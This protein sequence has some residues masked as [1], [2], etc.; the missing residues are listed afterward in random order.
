MRYASVFLNGNF[1][2]V[3]GRID[4][5]WSTKIARLDTANWS[6]SQA[7]ELNQARYEHRAIWV[8]SKLVVVGGKWGTKPI[9]FCKLENDE[10]LGKKFTCT[11]QNST[12]PQDSKYPLLFA[13]SDD[14]KNC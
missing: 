1:Y 6:W 5:K 3:G 8:N 14:Y 9:E 13:V 2:I 11:V 4:F 10:A 12:M 7:G